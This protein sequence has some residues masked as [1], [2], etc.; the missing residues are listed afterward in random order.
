MTRPAGWSATA[1]PGRYCL[2]RFRSARLSDVFDEVGRYGENRNRVLPEREDYEV[3]QRR[4]PGGRPVR[5][6]PSQLLRPASLRFTSPARLA[7]VDNPSGRTYT[8][9]PMKYPA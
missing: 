4:R 1:P 9:G 2:L 3:E 7:R 8:Q 6:R 5:H